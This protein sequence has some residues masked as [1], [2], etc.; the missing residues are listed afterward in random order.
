MATTTEEHETLRNGFTNTT[1]PTFDEDITTPNQDSAIAELQAALGPLLLTQRDKNSTPFP[2]ST[3]TSGYDTPP[4]ETPYTWT[5]TFRLFD[6]PRE[7]RDEIYRYVLHRPSGVYYTPHVSKGF[8]WNR[9]KVDDILNLFLVSKQVY[10]EA[11]D[12]FCRCNTVILSTRYTS[13]REGLAK[14]LQG[15]LRL[16][17]ERAARG[18]TT[19][20][21]AYHDIVARP[22]SQYGHAPSHASAAMGGDDTEGYR[23]DNSSEETFY[24][25]LRDAHV[26][27]GFFPKLKVFHATWN[28]RTY[29]PLAH[30]AEAMKWDTNREECIATWLQLMRGWLQS[31]KVVP[32]ACV[33]FSFDGFAWC[34]YGER[35]DGLVNEAYQTIVREWKAPR[36]DIEDSGKIWLEELDKEHAAK[37][38]KKKSGKKVT[39]CA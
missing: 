21:N 25:I 28:P 12:M 32:L 19:V 15:Q 8:W 37:K 20:S 16:F 13:D 36:V 18:L 29:G 17:P 9:E 33:R 22:Y 5:G 31:G 35:L 14:P 2:P 24:E 39:Q 34:G 27:Q 6:F 30:N 26:L 1:A 23:K 11:F 7:L 10:Q 4:P 3:T 38:G